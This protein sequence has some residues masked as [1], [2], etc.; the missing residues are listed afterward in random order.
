[1]DNSPGCTAQS[2]L[3]VNWMRRNA[4]MQQRLPKT[5]GQ[6]KSSGREATDRGPTDNFLERESTESGIISPEK[7]KILEKHAREFPEG[8]PAVRRTRPDKGD[9]PVTER[10]DSGGTMKVYEKKA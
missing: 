3:R 5:P 2:L 10:D 1:M 6:A 9:I 7:N 8:D 4:Q